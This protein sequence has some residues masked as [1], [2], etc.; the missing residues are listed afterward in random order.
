[1]LKKIPVI[2]ILLLAAGLRFYNLAG[3][4]LWADE[5]NSV[6]LVTVGW[7][8][9]ARRT[10]FDIHPPF[11]YWLLKSWV[12][13]FGTGE[14]ALRSLSAVLG[15]G[16]VFLV[17]RLGHYFFNRW[18]GTI[19]AFVAAISPLLVYYSQ[20]TRMYMLLSFLGCLTVW[21]AAKL[22]AE[23]L[24]GWLVVAYI[25]T[26]TAGLYTHYAFPVMLAV[27][28]LGALLYLWQSEQLTLSSGALRNWL[29]WQVLP[30][31]LY[32]PW[33]P[34]A[35]RQLTTWP[36]GDFP[37]PLPE[38]VQTTA[39]TLLLGLSWPYQQLSGMGV[40]VMMFVLIL[41]ALFHIL[42]MARVA[43]FRPWLLLLYL[44]FLLP[45]LLTLYI[46]SPA[47][48]K[49]LSI[50]VPPLALLLAVTAL[51]LYFATPKR[52]LG[53]LLVGLLLLEVSG[54]SF[55]SLANYYNNPAFA[56]DDYRGIARFIHS[57][58]TATDAVILNA[59]GQQDVFGYYYNGAA[60][61]YPMPRRRPLDQDETVANLERIAAEA[62][63]IY[64]V[65]WAE[66][67]ADPTGVIENWLN[68]EL[69]KATDR[70][71]GNVRLVS[72]ATPHQ[73]LSLEPIDVPFGSAIR[74]TAV[75]VTPRQITPGDIL[76]VGLEWRADTPVGEDYTVFLQLLD[77][78]NHLVGQRDAA[79]Q[80][81]T[82]AWQVDTPVSDQHGIL[83]EPGTPPG[84]YQLVAGLYNSRNGERLIADQATGTDFI[85][86]GVV[87]VIVPDPPL[88]AEAF[89]I[90]N[91]MDVGLHDLRLLG[92]DLY[93]VGHRSTPDTPLTSNDPLR[94]VLY[95][96]AATSAPAIA[97]QVTI[98][99]VN[100]TGINPG[101]TVSGPLA[102]L[103]YP[104]EQWQSSEIVRGQF[105][106]F[107]SGV[108]P[109][110]YRPV[111]TVST[112]EGN[113][114]VQVTGMPFRVQ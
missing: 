18:V 102:G 77:G 58:T 3:Q 75:G 99:L 71:F 24:K 45:V 44:W 103:H 32:I 111:F 105:D 43:K 68:A 25:L 61:V 31:I 30:V 66:Q 52:W 88:P 81:P 108:L 27:V 94:V 113:D 26:I 9:I 97:D 55:V 14:T 91:Q 53:I 64:V 109:G 29:L 80:I 11:Y 72:Y 104:P 42:G 49:F 7:G 93:K 48:L 54:S 62:D 16:V 107:L 12:S 51:E 17:W 87:Q 15:V 6:A 21:L 74:L 56:R 2:L 38:M 10:A 41:P 112:S 100:T 47:F 13:L 78:T 19:A 79:P 92:Y 89:T 36:A 20:E 40:V 59:E 37:P 57:M 70:W 22:L 67:Q 98:D 33:I 34:V 82:T 106:L 84:N 86:L 85:D 83:V 50:A 114:P 46:F 69:Y 28:N 4:S 101:V 1:M 23:P 76:Q 65:Y 60:P 96:Q 5:G 110:E 39:V 63:D 95:W 8:E 73:E 35:W 90:Q